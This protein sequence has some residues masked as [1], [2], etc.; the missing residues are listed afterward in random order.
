M[1]ALRHLSAVPGAC[2]AGFF[3]QTAGQR[4]KN[5]C[6]ISNATGNRTARTPER[7]RRANFYRQ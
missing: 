1:A 3:A 5:G 2:G 7:L 4:S 6:R